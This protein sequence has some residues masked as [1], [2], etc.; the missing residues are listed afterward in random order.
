MKR[1]LAK[2][3]FVV[4]CVTS[5]LTGVFS[6][7]GV[8]ANEEVAQSDMPEKHMVVL[9]CRSPEAVAC[10]SLEAIADKYAE[11]VNPNFSL[12][13]Q[14]VSEMKE[15]KQK[16][17]TLIASGEDPDMFSMDADPYA[18]TLLSTGILKDITEFCKENNLADKYYDAPFQWGAFSDGV[19]IGLPVET[20]IEMFW[21]NKEL[22]EKAGVEVPTTMDEFMDTCEKLKEAEITPISIS[23]KEPWTV[24][25]YLTRYAFRLEGNDFCNGMVRGERSWKEDTGVKAATFVQKLGNYFQEGFAS[26]DITAAEDYFLSGNAAIYYIGTWDLDYFQ[27]DNLNE[28]MKGKVDY[29]TLPVIE[30]GATTANEY[31][32]HGGT[33][34]AFGAKNWDETTEDFIL[35]YIEHYGEYC[36]EGGLFSPIKGYDAPN[37]TELTKKVE[38]DINSEVGAVRLMDVD[39]DPATNEVLNKEVVSLATGDITVEDFC[40]RMD[41][42]IQENASEYYDGTW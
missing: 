11:E 22:F 19:Q 30:G 39:T 42:A 28:N 8:K 31:I 35:Y 4:V 41:E 34:W 13:I 40:D 14:T 25:R 37:D 36:A 33:P 29:F 32:A 38:N 12:E 6:E 15:Y 10:T 20:D 23:G 3:M 18:R 27:E 2:K 16:I 17:K 1:R 21:Y 26:Y 9:A 5:L 7:C 24:I